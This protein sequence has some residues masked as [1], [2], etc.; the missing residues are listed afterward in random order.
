MSEWIGSVREGVSDPDAFQYVDTCLGQLLGG[1]PEWDKCEPLVTVVGG[2]LQAERSLFLEQGLY[3]RL[4]RRHQV[5]VRSFGAGGKPKR[6]VA[7]RFRE[8]SD[9]LSSTSWRMKRVMRDLVSEF[10]KVSFE[11]DAGG[12][13]AIQQT[14]QR[15]QCRT[16]YPCL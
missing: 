3:S 7:E 9:R 11:Y 4:H 12:V 13:K 6:E 8:I 1:G 2:V 14:S 10:E 5:H 16:R 15:L